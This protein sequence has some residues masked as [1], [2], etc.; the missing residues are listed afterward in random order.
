MLLYGKQEAQASTSCW[1]ELL[2][3][4]NQTC[5][6]QCQSGTLIGSHKVTYLENWC[7]TV[8]DSVAMAVSQVAYSEKEVK[9]I[10]AIRCEE[11]DVEMA[12]DA[13]DLLTR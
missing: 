12:E 9:K 3:E 8:F 1:Q 13:L 7:E 2:H 6:K 10:L 11:E 4:L 5:S